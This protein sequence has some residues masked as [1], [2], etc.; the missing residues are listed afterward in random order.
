M[1]GRRWFAE[2][3]ED[4]ERADMLVSLG[5]FLALYQTG[6]DLP[7]YLEL[8]GRKLDGGALLPAS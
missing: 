4:I 7:A 2:L 5:S 6:N 3:R 1:D 8:I